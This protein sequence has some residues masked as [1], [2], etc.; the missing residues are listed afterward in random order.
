MGLGI[1]YR[2]VDQGPQLPVIIDAARGNALGEV[3]HNEI[4]ADAS[5]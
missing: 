3:D 2:L 5:D 1:R 4:F